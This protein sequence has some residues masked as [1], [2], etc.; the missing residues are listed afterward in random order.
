[1]VEIKDSMSQQDSRD[2]T[3]IAQSLAQGASVIRWQKGV[4]TNGA[5]EIRT[6]N[7]LQPRDLKCQYSLSMTCLVGSFWLSNI[8]W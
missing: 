7:D 3:L 2:K 8:F 1:M 4:G 5:K 6:T